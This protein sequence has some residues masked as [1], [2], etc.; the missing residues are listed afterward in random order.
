MLLLSR[1]LHEVIEIGPDITVMVTKIDGDRVVLGVDA[2]R[3][4]PVDRGEVADAKRREA[5]NGQ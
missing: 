2:P 4:V 1:K 5:T 3:S